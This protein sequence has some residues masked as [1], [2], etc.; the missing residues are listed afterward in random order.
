MIKPFNG[1]CIVSPFS[2]KWIMGFDTAYRRKD[3][4]R[5][6]EKNTR[7]SWRK[8]HRRGFRVIKVSVI[9]NNWVSQE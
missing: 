1:W 6:F 8:A 3:C 5:N 9:E 7:M 4:L 2:G